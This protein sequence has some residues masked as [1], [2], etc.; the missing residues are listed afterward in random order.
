MSRAELT[1]G[2]TET[3]CGRIAYRE[4]GGG[5]PALFIHGA[6]LNGELWNGTIEPLA[7]I[8][9]CI[10]ADLLAHGATEEA[11]GVD[12]SFAGQAEMLAQF[13]DALELGAV[14]LVA[15]DSGGGIAQ[16]FA[17]RHPA[18]VRSIALTNCDTHDGWPPEAFQ[19]TVDLI[20]S[21]KGRD[22]LRA[23]ARDPS[24][25][26]NAFSSGFEY[27]E[28]VSDEVLRIFFAPLVRSDARIAALETFF[29][30]MDC[31]QTVEIEPQ[32][33]TLDVPALIVWGRSDMFFERRWA[34]W[35]RDTLPHVTRVVELPSA[36]LFFPLDRP[37]DLA[38]E[39]ELFW[40]A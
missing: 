30:A 24:V 31:M 14:D 12:L 9:R 7:G 8:R 37:A 18:K 35:L 11:E 4:Q 20:G 25:A 39:L 16:I 22:L 23:L 34:Y 21:G 27:P 32:L 29:R 28:R 6:F 13:V 38:R 1:V 2:D 36:R 15:N 10:A 5:P 40:E 26:R 33:K 3:A 19:P 17:A